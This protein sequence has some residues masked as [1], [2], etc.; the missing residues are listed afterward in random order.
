MHHPVILTTLTT[1]T[2]LISALPLFTP[3]GPD[4]DFGLS[5]RIGPLRA[6]TP[7]LPITI[8]SIVGSD[9]EDGSLK[10]DSPTDAIEELLPVGVLRGADGN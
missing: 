9:D 3:R 6:S 4:D 7:K 2:A 8:P 5:P 1:F 10:A